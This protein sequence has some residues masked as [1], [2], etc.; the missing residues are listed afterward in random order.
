MRVMQV[1]GRFAPE[2]CG[3]AHYADRLG[4]ELARVGV[5]TTIAAGKTS[6]ASECSTLVVRGF[7]ESPS[8]LVELARAARAWSADWLHLQF[9]PGTFDRRRMVTLLPLVRRL[10]P[11]APRIATTLHEYGGWPIEA[12][13]EFR[14]VFDRAFGVAERH[15]WLDRESLALLSLSDLAIVTNPDHAV[16]IRARSNALARRITIV[17]V[18]PNVATTAC[19]EP[20]RDEA[21]RWLGQRDDRLILL[22][23][24]FVHPVKG[25]ETLIRALRLVRARWPRVAL[26][27]VGG[28]ESLALRGDEATSYETS[29]RSLLAAEGVADVVELTGYRPDAE[30]IQRLAAADLAVL[31]FNHGATLKSGTLVTCLSHGL[32]TITTR[33]GNLESLRHG[34]HLWL[35]SPRDPVALAEAVLMLA[36]DGERRRRLGRSASDVSGYF[37]WEAIAE[38]H[39]QLYQRA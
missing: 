1:V 15:G 36:A 18:G 30:V 26:W 9:A 25:I 3:V 10:V 29:I 4:R 37:S 23:F 12:P 34:V 27:I 14:R 16:A 2:R 17:P 24:G 32:P 21:R 5:T 33:G 35:V 31:P 39:K 20:S 8:G 22:Y 11:G 7:P 13:G 38:R 28:I 19:G 6:A